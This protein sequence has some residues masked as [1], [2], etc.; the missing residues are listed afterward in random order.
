MKTK[1]HGNVKKYIYLY[2]FYFL[3]NSINAGRVHEQSFGEYCLPVNG[4]AFTYN[5]SE[6]DLKYIDNF[7]LGRINCNKSK[8]EKYV[9]TNSKCILKLPV[10]VNA[11]DKNKVAVIIDAYHQ[12]L[13]DLE[14][15]TVIEGDGSVKSTIEKDF[16]AILG[17]DYSSAFDEINHWKK[18]GTISFKNNSYIFDHN[19][20]IYLTNKIDE[21]LN[22][23]NELN[24]FIKKN[25]FAPET[26]RKFLQYYEKTKAI[27][28]IEYEVFK[29]EDKTRCLIDADV[30][31]F[32]I[33]LTK[34]EVFACV[35]TGKGLNDN[36]KLI[37][38]SKN[39]VL[40]GPKV[41]IKDPVFTEKYVIWK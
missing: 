6:T 28:E 29:N 3:V 13:I 38:E 39:A 14:K 23:K 2:I 24:N 30:S 41:H 12:Y 36:Y 21:R 16:I 10:F 34:K 7:K 19:K 37:E 20:H 17:Y 18:I 22:S 5:L 25:E 26:Q 35:N 27:C 11:K 31:N 8:P 4:G 40:I 32:F 15:L 9:I 1:H 33:D